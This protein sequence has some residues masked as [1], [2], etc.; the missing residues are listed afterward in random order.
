MAVMDSVLK[1][2]LDRLRALRARYAAE[3]ALLPHGSV[4]IKTKSGHPYAYRAYRKG[5]RVI[6]D[7]VG[8]EASQQAKELAARLKKRRDI[9][10]EIRALDSET[11]RL[12]KMINAG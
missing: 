8:P 11:A 7:Y 2:E 1:E 5:H 10:R 4:V 3:R 9:T 12:R 6:T